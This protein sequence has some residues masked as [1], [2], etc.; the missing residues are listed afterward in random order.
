MATR[1]QA[2]PSPLFLRKAAIGWAI[3][4]FALLIAAAAAYSSMQSQPAVQDLSASA[5]RRDASVVFLS[6]DAGLPRW[7]LGKQVAQRLADDGYSVTAI[8]SLSAFSQRRSPAQAGAILAG[9][10]R[11]AMRR[12]P[13]APIVLLGQ[14]FGSDIIPIAVAHLPPDLRSRIA[15]IILTV[16]GTHAYLRVFPGEMLGTARPDL[17]LQPFV[18]SLPPVPLTCIYGVEEPDSLCRVISGPNFKSVALPGG[19]G[20]HRDAGAVFTLVERALRTG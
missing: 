12:N 16:P 14:S 7:S 18:R 13:G 2:S 10:M 6:G 8:D 4:L 20:L 3:A 9:A 1:R 15:R 19:H 11:D 17:A 5:Y